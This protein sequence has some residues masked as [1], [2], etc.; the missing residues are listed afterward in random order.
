MRYQE[1][2]Y[3]DENED[4][5]EKYNP[6]TD[7]IVGKIVLWVFLTPVLL[8]LLAAIVLFCILQFSGF[9]MGDVEEAL[10]RPPLSM[11]ERYAFHAEEK[12]VDIRLD[13][14]DLLFL[15][16]QPDM[17]FSIDFIRGEANKY[18]LAIHAYDAEPTDGGVNIL[19]DAAAF[20]IVPLPVKVETAV[21]GDKTD[22][23]LNI[24]KIWLTSRVS[25]TPRQLMALLE[26]P[27]VETDFNFR[28]SGED[29]HP[30]LANMTAAQFT[31]DAVVITCALTAGE[32]REA[33][34]SGDAFQEM[35]PYLDM[36]PAMQ[37]VLACRQK[38]DENYLGDAFHGALMKMEADPAYYITFRSDV[39]G[40]ATDAEREAYFAS[41]KPVLRNWFLPGLT[42]KSI[43]EAEQNTRGLYQKRLALFNGLSQALHNAYLSGELVNGGTAFYQKDGETP[44]A[45]SALT[46]LNWAEDYA[47]W[48]NEQDCIPVFVKNAPD[49]ATADVPNVEDMPLVGDK[50]L[51]GLRNNAPYPPGLVLKTK[52]NQYLLLFFNGSGQEVHP[53]TDGAY[54]AY[55]TGKRIPIVD[56]LATLHPELL[57]EGVAK[58][59][60]DDSDH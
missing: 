6:R 38:G 23:V 19:L 25:M 33:L 60:L 10:A 53:L 28:I 9:P 50:A 51:N 55:H 15:S 18:G 14:A 58:E 20:G 1:D 3:Y 40:C 34:S 27:F 13:R 56:Y 42:E 46:N 37:M 59:D 32:F 26:Q 41:V 30:R 4:Y 22:F 5:G 47:P 11:G 43:S 48:L 24:E 49:A 16:Q 54:A 21:Y 17:P 2:D 12:T 7:S 44:F 52:T 35:L 31:K 45:M 36:T 39:L 57:P 8:G 29:I